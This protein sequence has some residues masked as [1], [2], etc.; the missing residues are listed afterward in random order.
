MFLDW[1]GRNYLGVVRWQDWNYVTWEQLCRHG[2][3]QLKWKY[4]SQFMELLEDVFPESNWSYQRSFWGSLENQRIFLDKVGQSKL[5]IKRLEA[6]YDVSIEQLENVGANSLITNIYYGSPSN[7]MISVYPEY[8]WLFW[9]FIKPPKHCWEKPE[10]QRQFLDWMGEHKL[11]IRTMNDWYDVTRD[12]LLQ[13]GATRLLMDTFS[14]SIVSMLLTAYPNYNWEL[15]KFPQIPEH[16]WNKLTNQ[17]KFLDWLGTHKLSLQSP[18]DWHDMTKRRLLTNGA[19]PL[20]NLYDHSL[21]NMY[22]AIYPEMHFQVNG[23]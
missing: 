15:M 12:Q 3:T 16:F 6:W 20:L 18:E 22:K 11:N 14:G 7:M 19:R 17:R 23:M 8:N 21:M 10:S 4:N 13:A 9:R 1:V 2:A 5:N